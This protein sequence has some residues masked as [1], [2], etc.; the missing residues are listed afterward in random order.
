MEITPLRAIKPFQPH[1]TIRV[2]VAR[3]WR[4]RFPN[5][6]DYNGLH[7]ILIDENG[8]SI[9]ALISEDQHDDMS[10]NVELGQLYDISRF[11]TRQDSRPFRVLENEIVIH[12]NGSTQF[13]ELDE[14]LHSIPQY[15]FRLIDFEELENDQSNEV[16]IG[17][18]QFLCV[19]MTLTFE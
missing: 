16:L 9:H 14:T 13:V 12:F 3:L 5:R 4:P 6:E 18:Y 11:S 17:K 10:H 8:D 15:S 2:R 1:Y 7:Y 19:Y